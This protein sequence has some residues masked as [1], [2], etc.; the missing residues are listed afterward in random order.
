MGI[1]ASKELTEA[2]ASRITVRFPNGSAVSGGRT[3]AT[4]PAPTF[5]QEKH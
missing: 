2:S 5:L 4:R 1:C 3:I